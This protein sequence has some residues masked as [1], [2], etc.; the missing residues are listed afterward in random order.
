[1]RNRIMAGDTGRLL[2]ALAIA[3]ALAISVAA[4]G[5]SA[6]ATQ[7]PAASEAAASVAVESIAPEPSAETTTVQVDQAI[8]FAGFKVALGAATAEITEGRGGTVAI[9]AAFENTGSEDARFDGTLNLSSA[10]ENATEAFDMDIPSVPGGLSGKGML[11][12]DVEDSFTFDDA[13]L[14]IGLP[15]NQ[16]AIVPLTATA[17]TAV[18]LEPVAVD[19]TGE[20][21]AD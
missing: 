7:A 12:F 16:Q 17:G 20:G 19:A 6:A 18:T 4:C 11:T 8:S 5:G 13:V 2:P 9:E 14:T 15:A 10:G 3:G 1:M 21:T